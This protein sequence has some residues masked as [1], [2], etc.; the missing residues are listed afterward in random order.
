MPDQAVFGVLRSAFSSSPPSLGGGTSASM[1]VG[2]STVPGIPKSWYPFARSFLQHLQQ[3]LQKFLLAS[4]HALTMKQYTLEYVYTLD[5]SKQT[6][7]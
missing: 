5:A 7:R 6:I 4:T 3:M 2:F 1:Y